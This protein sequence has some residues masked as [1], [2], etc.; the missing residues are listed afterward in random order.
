MYRRDKRR[1]AQ[2]I[3]NGFALIGPA[4][5]RSKRQCRN[6]RIRYLVCHIE[7][8][9]K[10]G[11]GDKGVSRTGAVSAETPVPKVRSAERREK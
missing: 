8:R 4:A 2:E 7:G 1:W 9:A 3:A 6:L 10:E 11:R 5:K